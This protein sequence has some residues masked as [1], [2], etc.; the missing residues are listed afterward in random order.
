MG[1]V[2]CPIKLLDY[3]KSNSQ[4]RTAIHAGRDISVYFPPATSL[5]REIGRQSGPCCLVPRSQAS[6]PVL[7]AG[8]DDPLPF[9]SVEL[10]WPQAK[11]FLKLNLKSLPRYRVSV[12]SYVRA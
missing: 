2:Y 12:G 10:H 7:V 8:I 6:R 4:P 11:S 1:F 5:K 9:G 3:S